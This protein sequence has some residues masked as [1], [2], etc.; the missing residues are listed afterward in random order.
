MNKIKRI[1]LSVLAACMCFATV[2]CGGGNNDNGGSTTNEFH[3]QIFTGAYNNKMWTDVLREFKK[4]HP[5]YKVVQHMSNT[6]N[7]DFANDW[8]K[9]TPPDFV[10]LDGELEKDE[11]LK[12]DMLYDFTEWL[13]T[14]TVNGEDVKV[15]DKV[16]LNYAFKYTNKKGNTITY[17]MPLLVSSY[18]IWYDQAL[19]ESN[20]W[21]VPTNYAELKAF[22]EA[23]ATASRSA[24]IYPGDNA[25]GYM[26]QGLILPAL[27]EVGS[28]FYNRVENA[29]DA[30]VYESA[31]FKKVMYRFAEY[32]DLNNVFAKGSDG[33][34]ESL[35]LRHIEAQRKWLNHEALLIPNGLWLRSEMDNKSN[36][37]EGI[38]SGFKMRYTSSPLVESKRIIVASSVTFGIAKN[39]KNKKAALEFATYLYRDDIVKSFSKYSDAPS[40][41]KVDMSDVDV[42]DVLK[43]TQSVMNDKETYTFVNHVGSWGGVDAVFNQGVNAIVAGKKT[44][45]GKDITDR[46]QIV[47]EVCKELAAKAKE[48]ISKR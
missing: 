18:G 3:L 6:V 36:N 14:A 39:A 44:V 13:E 32:C 48:V 33:I 16:D 5:E 34:V 28:D 47:D 38:P 35:S 31:E 37:S 7:D 10:F 27:A 19:F 40:V 46:K 9:N 8:K 4:D 11:W 30:E 20:N 17:G 29:L 23:N 12:A 42:S 24:M 22:T 41:A 26:V 1:A 2:A 15:K 25:A 21:S 43:Y 45:N